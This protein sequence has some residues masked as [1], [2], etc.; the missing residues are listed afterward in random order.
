ML[1]KELGLSPLQVFWWRQT[2]KLW[3]QI[4]SSPIGLLFHTILLDNLDDV[5]SVRNSAKNF[6]GSIATCLQSIGQPMPLDRGAIPVLEV[7]TIVKALRQHL[8]G[9]HDSSNF[10]G[11]LLSNALNILVLIVY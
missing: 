9:I 11:A 1:L 4:A 3:N 2:L 10:F 5:F 7:G 8:G 6:S